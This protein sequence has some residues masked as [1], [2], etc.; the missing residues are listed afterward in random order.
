MLGLGKSETEWGIRFDGGEKWG[1]SSKREAE[2]ACKRMNKNLRRG[3][4]P[5]KVIQRTKKLSAIRGNPKDKCV[6]GKCK[7][8]GSVCKKHF[9]AMTRGSRA[10]G[11]QYTASD[12]SLEGIHKRWDE[13]GHRWS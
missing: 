1:F 9:A 2:G 5:A 7:K 4:T 8:N 6:G 11:G 10:R 12:W 3:K 13:E